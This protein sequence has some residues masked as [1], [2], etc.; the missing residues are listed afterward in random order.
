MPSL[1]RLAQLTTCQLRAE[2][3][4]QI[5]SFAGKAGGAEVGEEG[6]A[7][8]VLETFF[9]ANKTCLKSPRKKQP[10]KGGRKTFC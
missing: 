1:C 5:F 8:F 7:W 9:G 6:V 4:G 10:R 3:I 2:H